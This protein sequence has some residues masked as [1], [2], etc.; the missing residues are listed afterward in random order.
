MICTQH[1]SSFRCTLRAWLSPVLGLL[2]AGALGVSASHVSAAETNLWSFNVTPYLWVA[3]VE[4]ETSLPDVPPSTPPEA[5]LF[6]TR[7]AGGA[8]LAAQV[9]YRSVGLWMDFAWLRLDTEAASPGP[10]FSG[11]GLQSDFIHTTAAL[12]YRLPLKGKF[13][14]DVL[15]GARLWYVSEEITATGGALPGFNAGGDQTWVDPIVGA[16]LRYDLNDR[17]SLIAKGTAGGFGAAADIGWEALG[18]VSYRCS[19][20]CSVA[21]GYRYLHEDYARE[22]VTFNTDIHGFILGVGFHF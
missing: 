9:R 5:T 3:G 8:M 11:V 18:A 7:I 21:L 4:A 22:N 16:D 10:A 14:A 17:W 15:A 13:H 2:T 20:W 12:S 19:D 1:G 6:E